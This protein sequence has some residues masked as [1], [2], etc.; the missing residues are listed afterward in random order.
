MLDTGKKN[1]KRLPVSLHIRL[2]SIASLR[3]SPQRQRA[4]EVPRCAR[5]LLSMAEIY[6]AGWTYKH[7]AMNDKHDRGDGV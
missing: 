4:L 7:I 6:S 3:C 2:E 5:S 1:L